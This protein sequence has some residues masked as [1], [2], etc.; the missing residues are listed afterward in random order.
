MILLVSL[1]LYPLNYKYKLVLC[2]EDPDPELCKE[3][4]ESALSEEE[5]INS[6]TDEVSSS[7]NE[8]YLLQPASSRALEM[9]ARL[10]ASS[11]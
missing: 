4:S 5:L 9:S 10:M 3:G 7:T 6:G 2:R 8:S 11:C 1:L